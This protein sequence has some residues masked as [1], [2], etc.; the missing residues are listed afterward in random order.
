[1]RQPTLEG[2]TS[3]DVVARARQ[4]V[5]LRPPPATSVFCQSGMVWLTQENDLRD[6]FLRTGE[7]FVFDRPGLVVIAAENGE[8]RLRL[9]LPWAADGRW[10][11][12]GGR[13]RSWRDRARALVRR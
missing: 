4:V 1:M 7:R 13:T 5:R 8:A 11:I 12:T 2:A 3:L 9:D 6:I 10:T